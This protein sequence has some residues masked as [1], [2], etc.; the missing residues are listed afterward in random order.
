[1]QVKAVFALGSCLL[2][3]MAFGGFLSMELPESRGQE[4]VT[5]PQPT[6]PQPTDPRPVVPNSK[7]LFAGG[8]KS[9]KACRLCHRGQIRELDPDQD[10]SFVLLNEPAITRFN[11]DYGIS[12]MRAGSGVS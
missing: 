3:V 1:M 8:Y 4:A 10:K 7:T 11:C 2:A 6:D 5:S 12:P 9:V